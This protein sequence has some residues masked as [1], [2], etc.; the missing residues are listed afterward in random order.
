MQIGPN[1][2]EVQEDGSLIMNGDDFLVKDEIMS[3]KMAGSF[4]IIMKSLKGTFNNIVVYDLDLDRSRSIQQVLR[5]NHKN[6]G[7]MFVDVSGAFPDDIPWVFWT[8][9]LATTL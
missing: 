2:L 1:V 5:F 9:R 3:G 7:L 8:R 6:A 4:V